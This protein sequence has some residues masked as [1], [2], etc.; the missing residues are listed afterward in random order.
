MA[1]ILVPLL[2]R[3]AV[4]LRMIDLP[5]A[6]KRHVGAIPRIGGIAIGVGV[7][8]AS[9]LLLPLRPELNAFLASALIVFVFGIADDRFNLHYRLKFSGQIVA[10]LTFILGG[11]VWLT[12]MP[13][14][15]AGAIPDWIGIPL[16]TVVLVGVTNA[17]NLADGMD[18]LAGGTGVL[19]AAVLGYLA[20]L[21]DDRQVG[22]SDHRRNARLSA[23]QHFSGACIHG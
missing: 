16:T 4:A 17:I 12:R 11:D 15:Y 22:D 8:I 6:R 18:G 5:D 7:F 19:A 23:L 20:Y 3:Y 10:A 9:S 1:I 14:L 21:G 2:S 13:F